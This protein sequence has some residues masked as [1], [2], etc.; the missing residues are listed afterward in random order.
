[1]L[2]A[3]RERYGVDGATG[4]NRAGYTELKD[5]QKEPVTKIKKSGRAL[6]HIT[7]SI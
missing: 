6:S 7:T 4:R 5:N 3:W 2:Q 1:M